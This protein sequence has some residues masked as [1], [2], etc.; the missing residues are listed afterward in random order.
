MKWSV[1]GRSRE[2]ATKGLSHH[3]ADFQRKSTDLFTDL[4]LG[5]RSD[6]FPRTPAGFFA[7]DANVVRRGEAETDPSA[8]DVKHRDLDRIGNDDSFTDFAPQD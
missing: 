4:Q 5:R 3:I 7:K 6:R 1:G 2:L 8:P